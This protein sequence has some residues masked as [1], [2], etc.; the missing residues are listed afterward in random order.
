MSPKTS[1]D[2]LISFLFKVRISRYP[3]KASAFTHLYCS[4]EIGKQQHR[5]MPAFI[6][7]TTKARWFLERMIM[8][9]FF[10]WLYDFY[11]RIFAAWRKWMKNAKDDE[12]NG[13][14]DD[15]IW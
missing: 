14:N 7:P 8:K 1:G 5:L 9:H 4:T 12:D 13:K 10:S 11:R 2:N 6:P 3:G 15:W